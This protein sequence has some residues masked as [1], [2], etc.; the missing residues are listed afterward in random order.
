M[1]DDYADYLTPVHNK[2]RVQTTTTT[3]TSDG[4]FNVWRESVG[5][6]V[7][8]VVGTVLGYPFDCV[9]T[10]MQT[11]Q[12]SISSA[13]GAILKENGLHGL[14]RGMAS[15][16]TAL[17]I[18]N[19]MNFSSYAHFCS[20]LGV[21]SAKQQQNSNKVRQTIF[22][23]RYGVAA[24]LVGPLASTVSTPF[25]LIKTQTQLLQ[26]H[27]L[28]QKAPAGAE[29]VRGSLSMTRFLVQQHGIRC[30]YRGHAVNTLREVVFLSTY[31][32]VYEHCR[33]F[34]QQ[35]LSI[36]ENFAIPISGGLSGAVG[37][38]VSFPLDNIKSNIQGQSFSSVM[39]PLSWFS[40]GK[41][42][43]QTKGFI[44]LYSG[45]LPSIVRA[46][47]V[48]ASRFTA[49]ETAMAWLDDDQ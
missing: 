46:F 15:P 32:T 29:N 9:K 3:V 10:R 43:M 25:E 38:F 49:Y 41:Q 18:L 7:A 13:I 24:A 23:W 1:N 34:V 26:K 21:N 27:I 14:Y 16:L 48:S 8:G 35:S 30:L 36:S 6:G 22:E 40:V 28:E 12:S 37:W 20:L 5:G 33:Q 42:L 39:R 31:F 19:T 2:G 17:T 44:G 4:R 45:V 11:S 47:I